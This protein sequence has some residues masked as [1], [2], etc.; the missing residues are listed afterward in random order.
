MIASAHPTTHSCQSQGVS[1]APSFGEV[2]RGKAYVSMAT[3]MKFLGIC[4]NTLKALLSSG[5][6]ELYRT[7]G[8]HRR[9]NARSLWVYA[10][11]EDPSEQET[12]QGRLV[13]II[14]VSSRGQASAKGGSEKSSL[15][16]QRD[17]ITE[18]CVAKYG[19]EPDE[20]IESVGSGLNFDRPEL[21]ELIRRITSGELRG[22][23]LVATDF[24][25]ICRF[26]VRM[27]EHLCDTFGV[28]IEYTLKEGQEEKG[29]N[30]S[31]VD[32]VLSVLTHFTARISGKKTRTILKVFMDETS[33]QDAYR[34]YREGYSYRSI[35]KRFEGEGRKDSKGRKYTGSVVRV[36]L[37]ENWAALSSLS[38][39]VEEPRTSFEEFVKKMLR[40]V[41]GAAKVSRKT[42][43]EKYRDWAT[44][45]EV[46]PM[47]DRKISVVIQKLGWEPRF[48]S[49]GSVCYA[50]L[51]MLR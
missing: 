18:Y 19:R 42:I 39:E 5:E 51:A 12:A 15:D 41:E 35:A 34:L 36:C 26:G 46:E 44:T 27:I 37:Q 40:K 20:I 32:D 17:R 9:I 8:G 38:G 48:N 43:V 49:H 22:A 31:L 33:L 3:A 1:L 4:R 25:R 50:G 10:Y 13:G 29:E 7:T 24:T 30:E 21:L 14:R 45:R 28:S 16:H 11:G 47:T 23:T 2:F 6:I